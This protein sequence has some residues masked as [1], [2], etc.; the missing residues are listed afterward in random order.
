M[1]G[2]LERHI[3]FSAIAIYCILA[4]ICCG[5]IF[6]IYTFRKNSNIQRDNIEQNNK[7]LTITNKLIFLIEQAQT[8]TNH[9]L[10][11]K[12]E[13]YLEI[14]ENYS[15]EVKQLIDSLSVLFDDEEQHNR[16]LEINTLLENKKSVILEL[17]KQFIDY[18]PFDSIN[19]RILNYKPPID[20][21]FLITS[22]Y[23]T[24]IKT[25]SKKKFW[26][27][28]VDLFAPKKHADTVMT[29]R[30][31]KKDTLKMISDDNTAPLSNIQ[32][33]SKE[34]GKNYLIQMNKI[35]KQIDD[36]I[37]YEQEI[38]TQISNLLIELHQETLN[39]I[40]D[41]IDK[42]E[43]LLKRNYQFILIGGILSLIL[44]LVF[45]IMIIKDVNKGRSARKALEEANIF[46]ESLMENR[47]K[48]LLSI[49]HDIKA[50]MASILGYMDL[51]Q[52]D[53]VKSKELQG[54]PSMQNSGKYIIS[55][56]ENL[57]EFSSLEQGKL[58]IIQTSFHVQQLC[59]EI[60]EMFS[61]LAS[62]K[63]LSFKYEYSIIDEL[64]IYSDRI[65]IKQIV[66]N[67]LSNSIKY[68]IHGN[69]TF[70]VTLKKGNLHFKISD[71]GVGIPQ[72]EIN[73]LFEAFSRIGKH[74]S[75]A[76]GSGLGLYVVKGLVELLD[77][78]I[79]MNS[80]PEKGTQITIII[81]IEKIAN[82][83][84]P[85]DKTLNECIAFDKKYNI[86]IVDDDIS[87]LAM[88]KETLSTFEHNVTI[89]AS[90]TEF[91]QYL[92]K[93]SGFDIIL[94][95]M[96]MGAISGK[97]ILKKVR[98]VNISI[99]VIIMTA[100]SEF[101]KIKAIN[102]GFDGYLSKP[103]S[104]LSLS[105]IFGGNLQQSF[106]MPLQHSD[107]DLTSLTEMLDGDKN[108]I[109]NILKTF[110][111]ATT[112]NIA[113][114]RKSLENKDIVSAQSI[115]HKML[116][117]FA[118]LNAFKTVEILKKMDISRGKKINEYPE[119]KNDIIELIQLA[120]ELICKI[121]KQVYDF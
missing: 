99:P 103:F 98:N 119:W 27:R 102:Q 86:L 22:H 59:N 50:P 80:K 28:L 108:A 81:P 95:D 69:V 52:Q 10:S 2:N 114:L 79:I 48:L 72:D 16:L 17:N 14:Y 97:D 18:N 106:D 65:K 91:E 101:D 42:S 35:K 41:D 7:A 19:Q 61:P 45:I 93:L 13:K 63:Q 107:Y 118:Q 112:D 92:H 12:D 115:C 40:M 100:R 66:C 77:G 29:V 78:E 85:E 46:T 15:L 6:Y 51:W 96:E 83:Q 109:E 120:E 88:L 9:Y 121:K 20:S 90:M 37:E 68:T 60:A 76:K 11:S 62:Q 31:L 25:P 4:L 1:K 5:L 32:R 38:S 116:P 33:A 54:L 110:M 49:S 74:N 64:F 55:L 58:K 82:T 21:L 30:T 56:L 53:P 57:L 113:L 47:H 94:T 75:L 34:A 87:L 104:L 39:S 23:D 84:N 43:Y 89:C 73:N 36:L 70:H 8:A 44:A 105:N 67:L 71:T 117:M 3:R 111:D 26:V 24:I